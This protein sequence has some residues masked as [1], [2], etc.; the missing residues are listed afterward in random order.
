MSGKPWKT[1]ASLERRTRVPTETGWRTEYDRIEVPLEFDID[2]PGL[3]RQLG[4]KAFDNK[5]G[6]SR[7]LNGLIV[8]RAIK[9]KEAKA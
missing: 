8:V 6:K 2:W 5:S 3:A 1:K 7:F 9:P 4:Q